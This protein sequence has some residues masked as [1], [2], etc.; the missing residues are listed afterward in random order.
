MTDNTE[1][2]HIGVDVSS[3][4]L[5]LAA[6]H[7]VVDL[8]RQIENKAAAIKKWL[9]TLPE[10]AHLVCESSGP[11][12]KLLL[13][14]CWQAG[15]AVS[16]VNPERVR[17]LARAHALHA[18]TDTI[19][20]LLLAEFG[21]RQQPPPTPA[22]DPLRARLL[23]FNTRREQLISMRTMEL[24]RLKQPELDPSA[25]S[26]IRRTISMLK[27]EIKRIEK[28]IDSL[29][30]DSEELSAQVKLLCKVKGVAKR[31]ATSLLL[32]M[33]ELGTITRQNAASL[34]G[35][36]PFSRESGRWKGQRRIRAGRSSVR[37]SIYMAAL[38]AMRFN[39][40]L[41]AFAERLA[42][43]GKPFHLVI[44]AVMR[45]LLICLNS[46]LQK[47]LRPIPLNISLK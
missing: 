34:A 19:D 40:R 6:S 23:E 20:A 13:R 42:S 2:V 29:V 21:R 45:K 18:K 14:L 31:T 9:R 10:N 43:R 8:P 44:T 5:D 27:A 12:H 39:P 37:N 11:Y 22:P 1:K 15:V 32:T 35:L 26:S 38:T 17:A 41:K 28:D 7:P 4:K 25:T 33:P 16:R 36:A 24:N 46:I 30:S 3:E 47:H